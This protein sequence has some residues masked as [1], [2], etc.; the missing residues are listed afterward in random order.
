MANGFLLD[1]PFPN[2]AFAMLALKVIH[3]NHLISSTVST[4]KLIVFDEPHH[5]SNVSLFV[6]CFAGNHMACASRIP[7]KR[8]LDT[9]SQNRR[10]HIENIKIILIHFIIRMIR[11]RVPLIENRAAYSLEFSAGHYSIALGSMPPEK[12]SLFDS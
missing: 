2:C 8:L 10:F 1:P 4:K 6:G 7:R 9:A 11:Q 5:D 3:D 12:Y